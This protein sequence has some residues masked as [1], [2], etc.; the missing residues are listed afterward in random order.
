[1]PPPPPLSPPRTPRRK[2]P[3]L[4]RRRRRWGS[5]VSPLE[6]AGGGYERARAARIWENMERMQK[7]GILDLAQSLTNW[8]GDPAEGGG[9]G[10]P[11]SR[12]SAGAAPKVKPTPP[13][14]ARRSLRLKS[15]GP[16][17]YC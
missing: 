7:L 6:A 5:P 15:V 1:W 12:G 9:D 4:R 3:P 8:V 17:S 13:P 10:S 14:P 11:S 16:V 2:F